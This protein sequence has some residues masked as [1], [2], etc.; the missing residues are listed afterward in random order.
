MTVRAIIEKSNVKMIG[1]TDDPADD[2]KWHKL[3][4][5]DK[6]FKTAVCPTFRPDKAV[7]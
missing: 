1:T 5:E 2:L 3:I 4:A 7:I 6:S